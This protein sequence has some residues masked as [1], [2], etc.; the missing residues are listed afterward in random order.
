MG[1]GT[2]LQEVQNDSSV[3][4]NHPIMSSSLG[5]IIAFSMLHV[6][7][8]QRDDVEYLPFSVLFSS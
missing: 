2:R 7:Y 8:Y 5:Y 6:G 4:L 3:F 1:Q